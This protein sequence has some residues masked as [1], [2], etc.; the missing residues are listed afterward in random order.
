MKPDWRP[1]QLSGTNGGFHCQIFLYSTAWTYGVVWH[2]FVLTTKFHEFAVTE[3]W[4]K[5]SFQTKKKADVLKAEVFPWKLLEKLRRRPLP[6]GLWTPTEHLL[7]SVWRGRLR[8]PLR[9]GSWWPSAQ[10]GSHLG[11]HSQALLDRRPTRVLF[12]PGEGK[13]EILGAV[14]KITLMTCLLSGPSATSWATCVN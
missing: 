11:L 1:I 9:T 3:Q 13:R 10:D 14:R 7:P 4:H 2:I 8:G 6:Q 12:W 5:S